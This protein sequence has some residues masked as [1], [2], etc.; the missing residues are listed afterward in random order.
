MHSVFIYCIDYC[1][2]DTAHMCSMYCRT[3]HHSENGISKYGP[4]APG[5]PRV[6]VQK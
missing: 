5:I 2:H 3:A 6:Q 1:M 4:L